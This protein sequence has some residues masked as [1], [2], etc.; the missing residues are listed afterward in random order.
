[1][2]ALRANAILRSAAHV[3]D[4][5]TDGTRPS[6]AATPTV[7]RVRVLAVSGAEP[8]PRG[9][10]RDGER[11]RS[12]R[13]GFRADGAPGAPGADGVNC[14]DL[15]GDGVQD[16]EEDLNGDG[17]V[18]VYDCNPAAGGAGY[19]RELAVRVLAEMTPEAFRV[20][21]ERDRGLA[22]LFDVVPALTQALKELKESA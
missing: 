9:G 7:E 2:V 18:D 20:L 11:G 3:D 10:S 13:H 8:R 4:R 22:D 14:W 12:R 6:S 15:D 19:E 21:R 1:M 17:S 16:P 5:G